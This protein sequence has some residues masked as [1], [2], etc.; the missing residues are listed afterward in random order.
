MRGKTVVS[1]IAL[2]ALLA[3]GEPAAATQPA[4]AGPRH[5]MLDAGPRND[6]PQ[7]RNS[8]AYR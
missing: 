8:A 1:A 6:G 5:A 3:V 7:P 2:L 4:E